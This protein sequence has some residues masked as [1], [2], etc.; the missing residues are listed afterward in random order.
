MVEV[1]RIPPHEVHSGVKSG[2]IL[3]VCG[4][5]DEAKFQESRL[6]GAISFKE[7]ESRLPTIPKEQE[8]VFYC[9]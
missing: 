7:F 8:I 1:K 9:G 3:F 5:E 6:E 4:Y 2:R